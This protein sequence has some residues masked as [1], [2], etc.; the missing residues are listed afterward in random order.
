MRKYF[1]STGGTTRGNYEKYA[2]VPN[3]HLGLHY[4]QD[5][6]NYSTTY[7][8]STM[9]GEQKHK[10][11]KQHAAHTNSKDS[12][13]QL[14]KAINTSQTIRFLLNGA[15]RKSAPGISNQMHEVVDRCP[16]LKVRFL[17]RSMAEEEEETEEPVGAVDTTNSLLKSAKTGRP[18]S[19]SAIQATIRE[20]DMILLTEY[21]KRV[22][23][24][25]LVQGMRYKT[26]Y[27][28]YMSGRTCTKSYYEGHHKFRVAVTEFIRLRD[29]ALT[30]YRLHRII[31][32]SFE[33]F[34]TVFL[35][36]EKLQRDMGLEEDAAPY[37]IY[38]DTDEM[39]IADIRK[40]DPTILH[41]VKRGKDSWWWNPFVPQ[42]T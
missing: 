42:F 15:Y 26:R 18:I 8:A 22:F 32:L 24:V 19:F 1:Q 30:F 14:M 21:Y 33:T 25:T 17:G 35:V 36:L 39:L 23:N 13:F 27:W 9:L 2:D 34:V 12:D 7:N 37:P 41:F 10:I 16:I 11:F 28:G 6:Q 29:D 31:T 5:M 38:V 3:V 40:L 4:T 20:S